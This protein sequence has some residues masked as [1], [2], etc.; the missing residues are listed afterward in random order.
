M[1]IC[2]QSVVCTTLF[3]SYGLGLFGKVA[4]AAGLALSFAIYAV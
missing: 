4:P 2:L 3:Y 1:A